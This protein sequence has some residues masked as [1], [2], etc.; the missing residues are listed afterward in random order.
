MFPLYFDVLSETYIATNQNSKRK[1]DEDFFAS[2]NKDLVEG[3]AFK[4]IRSTYLDFY[5]V[6]I[7]V[8]KY[9]LVLTLF[10]HIESHSEV[11]L[12]WKTK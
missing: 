2:E 8:Q 6:M 9:I 4:S 10:L 1:V 7:C 3:A 12:K 11:P 5:V